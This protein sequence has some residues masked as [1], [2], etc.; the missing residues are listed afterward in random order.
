[1]LYCNLNGLWFGAVSWM[2]VVLASFF[3]NEQMALHGWCFDC[4]LPAAAVGWME[5][6]GWLI[7]PVASS[8][9]FSVWFSGAAVSR[10]IIPAEQTEP[11]HLSSP[12][13][14]LHHTVLRNLLPRQLFCR[15]KGAA[16][17]AETGVVDGTTK[18]TYCLQ[19]FSFSKPKCSAL[20]TIIE[21]LI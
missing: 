1:M 20:A 15:Q 9:S 18:E 14:L 2:D 17:I 13:R 19:L 16:C 7:F 10:L 21:S 6:V 8:F 12:T 11:F 4:W 3:W 5:L